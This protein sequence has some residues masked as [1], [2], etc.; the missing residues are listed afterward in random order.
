MTTRLY[1]NQIFLRNKLHFCGPLHETFATM[2]YTRG[3]LS[4]F[5]KR[6][7]FT[8]GYVCLDLKIHQKIKVSR[9]LRKSQ[10]LYG[11]SRS[12]RICVIFV[13][14]MNVLGF[15]LPIRCS[16]LLNF[17]LHRISKLHLNPFIPTTKTTHIFPP[18]GNVEQELSQL[19]TK[20]ASQ[21]GNDR[22]QHR[23]GQLIPTLRPWWQ[24]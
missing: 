16:T 3:Q 4:I 15:S 1:S 8:K 14:G 21:T 6:K 17:F 10:H 20:F 23:I 9:K 19:S 24:C 12:F 2:Y 18:G 7:N 22:V 13:I 11:F 5:F